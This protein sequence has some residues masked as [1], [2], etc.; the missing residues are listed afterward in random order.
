MH[1]VVYSKA[2]SFSGKC[3][4][5]QPQYPW[6]GYDNVAWAAPPWETSAIL[7][8]NVSIDIRIVADGPIDAWE[9]FAGNSFTP[10]PMTAQ[11][12][13]F[14]TGRLYM[15]IESPAWPSGDGMAFPGLTPGE[16]LPSAPHI[17][18]HLNC[19]PTGADYCGFITVWYIKP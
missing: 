1:N 16:E 8:T 11:R 10:D 19:T 12:Y 2:F 3:G 6:D 14:G 7:I 13:F 4:I 5:Q 18:V 15:H 17:D 9:V